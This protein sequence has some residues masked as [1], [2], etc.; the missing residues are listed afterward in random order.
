MPK[1]SGLLGLLPTSR[2]LFGM[3]A[4]KQNSWIVPQKKQSSC[5]PAPKPQAKQLSKLLTLLVFHNSPLRSSS[6][7]QIQPAP[8]HLSNL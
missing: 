8:F 6:F 2:L 7:Q 4:I 1:Q 3:N 5:S